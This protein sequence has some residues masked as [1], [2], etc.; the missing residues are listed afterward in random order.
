MLCKT[1]YKAIVLYNGTLNQHCSPF[2][3]LVDS[4]VNF[5]SADI[6]DFVLAPFFRCWFPPHKTKPCS[7]NSHHNYWL[8]IKQWRSISQHRRSPD[9]RHTWSPEKLVDRGVTFLSSAV[10]FHGNQEENNVPNSGSFW[11]TR[12][13]HIQAVVHFH[14]TRN[15]TTFQ[16]VVRFRG[17]RKRI[18]L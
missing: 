16:I 2:K 12:K 14:R 3:H 13:N 4:L 15:G 6:T 17:T 9:V 7:L 11:T 18:A 10:K 5:V 1:S 8:R